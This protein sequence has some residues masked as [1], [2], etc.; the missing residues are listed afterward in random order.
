MHGLAKLRPI[1][2]NNIVKNW[3]YTQDLVN[4]SFNLVKIWHCII[5]L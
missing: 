2:N 1:T 5:N 4:L 3:P